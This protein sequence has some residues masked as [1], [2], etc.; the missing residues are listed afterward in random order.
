MARCSRCGVACLRKICVLQDDP[1]YM[2]CV[3]FVTDAVRL[4]L[5]WTG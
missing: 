4:D 2:Q 3:R 1:R 5:D